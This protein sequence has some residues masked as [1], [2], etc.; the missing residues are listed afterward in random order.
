MNLLNKPT[1]FL[2]LPIVV[3]AATFTYIT[4][5]FF[6]VS[7]APSAYYADKLLGIGH[8]IT[9][10]GNIITFTLTLV[11]VSVYPEK[12]REFMLRLFLLLS[13]IVVA[14]IYTSLIQHYNPNL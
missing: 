11:M 6:E 9:I 14:L 3:W 12:Q 2:Q 8:V 13:N 4:Y 10:F 5:L 7:D 1:S